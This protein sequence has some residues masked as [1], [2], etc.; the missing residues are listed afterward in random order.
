MYKITLS[1][2]EKEELIKVHKSLKEKKLADRVK[3]IILLSS[4][5]S[6]KHVAEI[7][8]LDDKSLYR[9]KELFTKGLDHLLELNYKGRIPKLSVDQEKELSIHLQ[10]HL[11]GSSKEIVSHIK[12][13]YDLDFTPDGLVIALH[14]LGFSYKKAKNVP[15]KAD[16]EKQVAFVKEYNE[17]RENLKQD[18]KIYFIDG[19]HPTHNTMPA[20]AWIKTG[21]EKEVKSNTGRKRININGVYSPVDQE[22]I[23]RDDER[24]N[25]QSTIELFKMIESKH[26]ELTKIYIY[27]DNAKYYYSKLVR[28]YL[29]DSRIE[30]IPLPTYSPNLNLIE[31]L[32]K[33]FK[34]NVIYNKY[35]EKFFQFKN[36]VFDFFENQIHTIKPELKSLMREKFHIVNTS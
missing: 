24:I 14:R 3:S 33:L 21:T 1:A 10:K 9:Y 23:V 8:L 13:K 25:S 16:R 20:Y 27:S 22:V 26:P 6:H 18:E 32:W 11:Y 36:A 17:L 15:S 19:V 31:R 12:T 5:Y 29:V 30:L 34:K 35:Y 2:N 7:L 4:G 28:E